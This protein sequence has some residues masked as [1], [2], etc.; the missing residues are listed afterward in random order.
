M[1]ISVKGELPIGEL[2][3]VLVG[4]ACVERESAGMEANNSCARILISR[5]DCGSGS[6]G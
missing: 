3:C 2:S 1:D 5:G 4:V 6:G